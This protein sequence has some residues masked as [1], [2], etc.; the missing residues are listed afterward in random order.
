M[1]SKRLEVLRALEATA[2]SLFRLVSA[3]EDLGLDDAQMLNELNWSQLSSD[4]DHVAWMFGDNAERV[5][6]VWGK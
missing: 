2:S 6:E 4:V 3:W 5:A 1:D